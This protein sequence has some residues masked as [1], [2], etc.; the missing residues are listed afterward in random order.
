MLAT[1][2]PATAR[3]QEPAADPDDPIAE[4]KD[5][6]YR[7]SAKFSASQYDDAIELFTAALELATLEGAD[8]R[9]RGALLQNLASAHERSYD[10]NE[11][12]THLKLSIDILRRYGREADKA[13]YAAEDVKKAEEDLARIEERLAQHDELQAAPAP[14]P[15]ANGDDGPADDPIHDDPTGESTVTDTPEG[16]KKRGIALVATGAVLLAGGG[17]AIGFGAIFVPRAKSQTEL[18]DDPADYEDDYLA[19]ERRNGAIWL[20]LGS[21]GAAVGLG[22]LIWGAVDLS[23]AKKAKSETARLRASPLM[24]REMTG[25]AIDGR[26]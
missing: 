4:M 11:D 13:G 2:A 17:G 7:G 8:P 15:V 6:F 1:I 21:V 3:A 20:G 10:L 23:R 16:N 24:G 18:F 19:T 22:L 26:F 12:K 25:I 9:I 14:G 5:L